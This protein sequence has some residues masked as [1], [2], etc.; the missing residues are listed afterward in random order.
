MPTVDFATIGVAA[1][2]LML[3][4]KWWWDYQQARQSRDDRLEP[5]ATPPLHKQY[6][7]LNTYKDDMGTINVRF[8]R[9]AES[10]KEIHG[11]VGKVR[12][13][14]AAIKT[15]N[16]SQTRQLQQLQA[17]VEN[18]PERIVKLINHTRPQ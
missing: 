2:L 7:D 18:M 6:V 5:R 10:R 17:A 14:I 11:E 9:A 3:G 13:E 4:S 15:D 1:V 16:T 12:E 8:S